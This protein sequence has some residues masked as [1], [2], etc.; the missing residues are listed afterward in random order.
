[1]AFTFVASATAINTGTAG[2][3][4]VS[5]SP[6]LNVAAGDLLVAYVEWQGA[7]TG[8]TLVVD[9]NDGTDTFTNGTQVVNSSDIGGQFAYLLSTPADASF[10]VRATI[11][12]SSRR[13][14]I[15]VLQFRPDAA[16]TVTMDV[17]NTGSG[18]S[19]SLLSGNITTTGTDEVVCGGGSDAEGG[20]AFSAMQLGDVNA[21]GSTGDGTSY[22]RIWYRILTEVM[23]AG[24]AQATSANGLWVCN[25]ISFKVEAAGGVTWGG[26][27]T[28]ILE[29]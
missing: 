6:A 9:E 8:N 10:T 20:T 13:L 21:T 25:I 16:E 17:Q 18:S 3:I 26:M 27:S 24:H 2:P 1:M 22:G 23:T 7:E 28:T 4:T 12:E 11:T 19:A 29:L 15:G 14:F 5:A